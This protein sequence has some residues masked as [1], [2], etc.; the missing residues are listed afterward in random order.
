[1]PSTTATIFGAIAKLA[2]WRAICAWYRRMTS[3]PIFYPN[4]EVLERESPLADKMRSAERLD[5][6]WLT[7]IKSIVEVQTVDKVDRLLLPDPESASMKY[8]QSLAENPR[9]LGD[10]IR[11]ATRQAREKKIKV[12][13]LTEFVGYS[14]TIW[15][16]KSD[17][18][19]VSI[20]MCFP[21]IHGSRH[22]CFE[23]QKPKH[24]ATVDDIKKIFDEL[25][26]EKHSKEPED[27][28]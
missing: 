13:W 4:A 9:D 6:M 14:L 18:A 10:E 17:N 23:F 11:S 19:S 5:A 28:N 27:G 1:M 25:W 8:F 2:T 16:P 3:H 7:G 24:A 20:K 26:S 12:R 21:V 15:N 22:P